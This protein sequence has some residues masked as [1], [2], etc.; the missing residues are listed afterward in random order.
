[1][2]LP[3]LRPCHSGSKLGQARVFQKGAIHPCR[4]NGCRAI[5]SQNQSH[6]VIEPVEPL[7]G[8][9]LGMRAPS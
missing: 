1:M 6:Q 4:Q 2:I 3:P 9:L 7:H 5:G 8:S